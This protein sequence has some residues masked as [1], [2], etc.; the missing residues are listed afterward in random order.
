MKA[1]K[2][3]HFLPS[4]LILVLAAAFVT[5]VLAGPPE[6]YDEEIDYT[7]PLD[8]PCGYDITDHVYGTLRLQYFFNEGRSLITGHAIFGPLKEIWSAN[9][10]S[11][12]VQISGPVFEIDLS[13][14]V[15][16]QSYKGTDVVIT[17]PGSGRIFGGSGN[18]TYKFDSSTEPWTLIEIV[19][20]AGTASWD[21]DP[22][23]TYLAP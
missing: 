11:V 7:G 16:I 20:A 19:K 6:F 2:K 8:N 4:I 22:V 3:F 12:N 18:F 15:L 10:K 17:V 9:G 1:Q 14:T 13:E 23:C 21:W 5:P